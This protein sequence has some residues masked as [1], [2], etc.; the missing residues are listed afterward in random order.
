MS[1][2]RHWGRLPLAGEKRDQENTVFAEK[3]QSASNIRNGGG[4]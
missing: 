3:P 1:T 4:Q 2:T